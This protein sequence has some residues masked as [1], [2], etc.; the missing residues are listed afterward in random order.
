MSL[1]EVNIL[2]LFCC[3]FNVNFNLTAELLTKRQLKTYEV[4]SDED[5]DEEEEE[6]DDKSSIK[7]DRSSR[8]SSSEDE[9]EWVWSAFFRAVW[10]RW[11]K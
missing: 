4:Y 10:E 3:C 1:S 9:E 11:F 2:Y 8:L 7:S 6:D 5:E